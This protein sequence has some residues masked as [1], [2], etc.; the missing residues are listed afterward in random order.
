MFVQSPLDF[1][2]KIQIIIID[3]C[4]KKTVSHKFEILPDIIKVK[5]IKT[6]NTINNFSLFLMFMKRNY[7][8][9]LSHRELIGFMSS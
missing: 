5:C 3:T 8:G 1:Y 7:S 2:N 6:E 9:H 4:Y